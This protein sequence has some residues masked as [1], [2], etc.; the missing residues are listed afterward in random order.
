MAREQR[1]APTPE[2]SAAGGEPYR[3]AREVVRTVCHRAKNDL[4]TVTNLLALACPHLDS[5]RDLAR[6][7]EG[8]V[9]AL[10]VSYTLV[11]A[12]GEPPR[13][14][15]LAQEVVRRVLWSLERE[16][17]LEMDLPP[18]NLSLRLCSPLSL[19][20][21]EVVDNACRH[22]L[23]RVVSPALRLRAELDE[24]GLALEVAD[25]GPGLPPGLDPYHQGGL[26]L[27]VARAVAASDLRGGMSFR[28][29]EPGLAVRLM[30]PREQFTVLNR[31]TWP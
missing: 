26:G 21:H 24:E 2:P 15:L 8:R 14:D 4:Q 20:L 16:V 3:S 10:S 7:V 17:R 12:R 13:L 19:W 1:P 22:G 5:A 29:R 23:A 18:V 25:N 28:E 30:V 9:G 6:A 11:A 31:Q 27:R